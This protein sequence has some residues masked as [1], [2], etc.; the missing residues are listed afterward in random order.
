[1]KLGFGPNI[2][3]LRMDPALGFTLE[4]SPVQSF[5]WL[6]TAGILG[7]LL[8][9]PMRR[10]F[11]IDEKLTYADGVAAAETLIILDSK[12]SQAGL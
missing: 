6:S 2:S 4:I 8:A 12:G 10:H 5:M 11:V 9:V 7:V 1:M 3:M